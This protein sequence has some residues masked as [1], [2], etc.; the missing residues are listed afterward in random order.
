M[1][2]EVSDLVKFANQ[3]LKES[4]QQPLDQVQE[5]ILQQALQGLKLKEIRVTGYSDNTIQTILAPNLWKL[6]SDAT[7]KKVGIKTV[8]LILEALIQ[9]PETSHSVKQ[10]SPHVTPLSHLELELPGGQLNLSS[11]FYIERHPIEF[12]AYEEINKPGSLIRIKAPKQMGK[13]SLMARLLYHAQQQGCRTV[14]VNFELTDNEVFTD[15]NQFLRRFCAMVADD[16][17]LPIQLNQYWD[18]ELGSKNNCTNYFGRYLLPKLG[19]PLVL[20]LDA[21]DRIF[22][23]E[24]IAD[25][26]FGLLRAW[27]EKSKQIEIWKNLRLVIVHGTEVYLPL[28]IN[29]SP[30][31]VGLDAK[32][33]EFNQAQVK[34]LAKRYGFE[35]TERD[36]QQLM[37]MLGGHPHL[38][39]VAFYKMAREKMSLKQ[40]LEDAPKDTGIYGDYL[41]LH[42]WNLEKY[43]ELAQ[44]VRQ[45]LDADQMIELKSKLAFDLNSMGLVHLHGNKVEIRKKLYREYFRDRLKSTLIPQPLNLGKSEL[46]E[47]TPEQTK[48]VLATI[49]FTDVK[50]SVEKHHHNQEPTLAAVFRDLNLMTRLC[51]QFEGQVLKSVGDGLLMYFVSVVKAVKCAQEIQINFKNAAI[52]LPQEAI[53]EHR[54]GIHLADVYFNGNDVYGDGVNIAARLQTKANPGGICISSTVYEAVK[55]HL[56]LNI[57]QTE[58][59]DLKGIG[60]MQVYQIE[61]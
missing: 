17:Q 16:L 12:Q 5:A 33:P 34:E 42:L 1:D 38:L 18:E 44:A 28:D 57:I 22:G 30:F 7:G 10:L 43:P 41:R 39:R 9:N 56:Q 49:M 21:V 24:K 58:M 32:L 47:L 40:I 45:V 37:E 15:L 52:T 4:T 51:Q 13:T 50:D 23:H 20:G 2:Q 35:L 8:R 31:N 26:F 29:Q 11:S 6:L 54:I 25:D 19:Q 60:K 61:V 27:H 53:L 55:P 3:L 59:Q 46:L 36:I 48:N 14:V